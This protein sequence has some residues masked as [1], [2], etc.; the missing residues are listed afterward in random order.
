[1]GSGPKFNRFKSQFIADRPHL[2][3]GVGCAARERQRTRAAHWG[4]CAQDAYRKCILTHV[5]THPLVVSVQFV[6]NFKVAHRPEEIIMV[7]IGFHSGS[8]AAGV[9]R[10]LLRCCSC[11]SALRYRTTGR[12]SYNIYNSAMRLPCGFCVKFM[13]SA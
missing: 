10:F 4:H 7:R 5:L 13:R 12:T 3:G 1:M 6:S 9:V 2:H 11:V 8:V